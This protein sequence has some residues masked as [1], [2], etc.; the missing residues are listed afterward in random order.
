MP[1]APSLSPG[2]GSDPALA[3]AYMAVGSWRARVGAACP[4]PSP[5]CPLRRSP[6]P[7]C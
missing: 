1:L 3:G 6:V 7:G 2:Q 5:W 4:V